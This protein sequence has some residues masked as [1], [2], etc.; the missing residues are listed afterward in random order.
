MVGSLD[1]L[2]PT[3]QAFDARAEVHQARGMVCVQAGVAVTEALLLIRARALAD[4]RSMM[5]VALDVV[6]RALEFE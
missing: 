2:T 4:G 5:D 3:A 6:D 1:P